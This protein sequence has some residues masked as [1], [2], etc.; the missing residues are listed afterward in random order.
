MIDVSQHN[1]SIVWG[2]VNDKQVIIR[3]GYRGYTKGSL[4]QDANGTKMQL[5]H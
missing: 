1:G 2:N 3:M 4:V 5:G